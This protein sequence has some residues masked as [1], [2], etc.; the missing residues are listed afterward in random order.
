MPQRTFICIIRDP[1][2]PHS[3]DIKVPNLPKIDFDGPEG[4]E[5]SGQASQNKTR[6]KRLA[7]YNRL[8]R[9]NVTSEDRKG[10]A[11]GVRLLPIPSC[12]WCQTE[13]PESSNCGCRAFSTAR[14]CGGAVKKNCRRGISLVLEYYRTDSAH[15]LGRTWVG[16][17]V[18]A[19]GTNGST[20]IW[21]EVCVCLERLGGHGLS[22][23]LYPY[24]S[25]PTS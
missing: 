15:G 7:G 20:N 10:Q 4:L 21:R 9:A 6:K 19:R 16:V 24:G 8:T 5:L 18:N 3:S 2:I 17:I 11:T 13:R 1:L 14:P 12:A 23:K 22:A 25:V